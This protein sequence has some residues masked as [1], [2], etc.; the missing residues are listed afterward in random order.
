MTRVKLIDTS[1]PHW[2]SRR[3]TMEGEE[4][5]QNAAVDLSKLD[6]RTAKRLVKYRYVTDIKPGEVAAVEPVKTDPPPPKNPHKTVEP[7][8]KSDGPVGK[9]VHVKGGQYEVQDADGANLLPDRVK[10]KDMAR[11]AA[12]QMG[13]TITE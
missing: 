7:E 3:F 1:K 12:G 10:G 8:V 13:I 4:Y 5:Q 11:M 6:Q 2:A 9:L